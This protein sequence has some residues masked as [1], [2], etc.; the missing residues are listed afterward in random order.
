[1]I[2]QCSEKPKE[3]TFSHVWVMVA[4]LEMTPRGGKAPVGMCFEEAYGE[5]G[6]LDSS[7]C[8]RQ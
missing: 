7:E 5:D 3:R 1:M 8:K 2:S 4:A 6:G